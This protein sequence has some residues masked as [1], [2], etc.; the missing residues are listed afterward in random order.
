[1]RFR[2]A[3]SAVIL[4]SLVSAL[5]AAQD[6]YPR[7]KLLLEPSEL[8]KPQV[9]HRFVILDAR[10]K[11]AY[12]EQHEMVH[13]EYG[14]QGDKP[15]QDNFIECIRTRKKPNADVEIGHLSVL[16]FHMANISYRVGNKRLELDP[17][18]ERFTNCDEA[19]GYIKRTYRKP[20]VVPDNV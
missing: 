2:N 7:S 16:L 12:D 3:F 11:E 15:H 20:W 8:A 4:C 5:T 14:R 1:M 10:K 19:N 6:N 17:K 18:T 9:A 13:S